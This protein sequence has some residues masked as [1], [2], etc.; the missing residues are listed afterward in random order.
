MSGWGHTGVWCR[1]HTEK[2]MFTTE[3]NR[4]VFV[5]R[6]LV[7]FVDAVYR[8]KA[9]NSERCASSVMKNCTTGLGTVKKGLQSRVQYVPWHVVHV[10]LH[11]K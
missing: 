8:G 6:L 3:P 11:P 5:V 2:G 9:R 4:G 7:L 10:G 1:L